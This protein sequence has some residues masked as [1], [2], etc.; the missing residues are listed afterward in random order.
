MEEER[1][2]KA[3]AVVIGAYRR[4]LGNNGFVYSA[5]ISFNVFLAVIPFLFL[6]SMIGGLFFKGIL[7][8]ESRW[9]PLLE[10]LFPFAT[11]I[12][13]KNFQLLH[14]NSGALGLVGFLALFLATL[15]FTNA[16]H[17]SLS[18]M[19]G[20]GR[21]KS[22]LSIF[23]SHSV[24]IVAASVILM[25]IMVTLSALTFVEK[26]KIGIEYKLIK[27][28]L[29]ESMRIARHLIPFLVL[30]LASGFIYRHFSPVHV[31]FKH[32]LTGGFVFGGLA[33][34]GKTGF[35]LYLRYLSRMNVIYGSIFGI[36][37]FIIASY[38]FAIFFLFIG[39]VI[40]EALSHKREFE[41]VVGDDNLAGE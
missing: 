6:I 24:I 3:G 39:C 22:F 32:S 23:L 41:E 4:F 37:C 12:I 21:R 30:A 1:G 8:T 19:W 9:R 13:V 35:V 38:L 29:D 20:D 5:A 7:E 11:D 18:A 2:S 27:T 33:F 36:V 28:L 17:I 40:Y 26:T 31:P 15:S 10:D 14:K 16:I 34:L 25:G